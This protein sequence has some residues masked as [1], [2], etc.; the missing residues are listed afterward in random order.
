MGMSTHVVGFRLANEQWKK[1]KAVWDACK[2]ADVDVPA[3]VEAF[4][5]GEDPA[6]A[7]GMEVS[8]GDAVTK[9]GDDYRSGVEVD[10]TKLPAG[11]TILRFYDSW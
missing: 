3:Y 4:F 6:D 5:D 7:P 1:M 9:W 2:D 10:V 11:L 8:L